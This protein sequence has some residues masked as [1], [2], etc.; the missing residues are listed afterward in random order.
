MPE[1]AGRRPLAVEHFADEARCHPYSVLG[2]GARQLVGKGG[3][4]PPQ[5]RE[6]TAELVE[7]GVGEAGSDVP[8]VLQA[9]RPLNTQQQRADPSLASALPWTPSTDDDLLHVL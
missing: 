3:R 1:P 2:V 7:H 4:R 6:E 8:R 5:G 9:V